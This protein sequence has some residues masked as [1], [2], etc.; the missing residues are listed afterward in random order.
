MLNDQ[1]INFYKKSMVFTNNN[2][3]LKFDKNKFKDIFTGC[4]IHYY[5]Y[6]D[7]LVFGVCTPYEVY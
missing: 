2:D 5:S 1:T 7:F 4:I 3:K 6:S